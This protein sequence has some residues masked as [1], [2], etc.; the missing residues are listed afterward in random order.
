MPMMAPV[1]HPM[2]YP[3]FVSGAPTAYV[4]PSMMPPMVATYAPFYSLGHVQ[5]SMQPHELVSRKF[6]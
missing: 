3:S 6:N 4:I 5:P 2:P 1:S